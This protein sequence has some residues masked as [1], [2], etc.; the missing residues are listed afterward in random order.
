MKG[1]YKRFDKKLYIENDKAGKEVVRKT[2]NSKFFN[3]NIRVY[4]NLGKYDVDMTMYRGE[5]IIAYVE[6]E[7]K[8]NWSGYKFPFST[9]QIPERKDKFIGLGKPTIFCVVNSE[10]TR[11]FAVLDIHLTKDRLR[12]VPNK[13]VKEGEKFFQVPVLL[14]KFHEVK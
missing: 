13:Y 3:D 9:V 2:Y 6:V 14:G 10:K 7:V 12:V 8:H 5:D 1:V 4:P 11:F